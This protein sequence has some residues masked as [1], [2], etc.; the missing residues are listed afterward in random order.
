MTDSNQVFNKM[1]WSWRLL[2][3]GIIVIKIWWACIWHGILSN[4]SVDRILSK[5]KT[6][7]STNLKKSNYMLVCD[8]IKPYH[9]NL[10]RYNFVATSL[11]LRA[12]AVWRSANKD[13]VIKLNNVVK[14]LLDTMQI[15]FLGHQLSSK[16][17]HTSKSHLKP[18]NT[19]K[20]AYIHLSRIR[21]KNSSPA[22]QH[23]QSWGR[24]D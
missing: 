3:V 19:M 22:E 20:L 5:T 13:M 8:S 2:W 18:W 15:K 6:N 7:K 12:N 10:Y 1:R 17:M 23:P 14:K 9:D 4:I 16:T 24:L 11:T 21:S